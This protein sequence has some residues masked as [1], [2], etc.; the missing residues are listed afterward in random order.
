MDNNK[1]RVSRVQNIG[2]SKGITIPAAFLRAIGA[3]RGD[4]LRLDLDGKTILVRGLY[5]QNI[6]LS[7]ASRKSGPGKFL[8]KS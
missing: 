6:T 7:R 3:T 2:N 4:L 5:E 8:A 1:L